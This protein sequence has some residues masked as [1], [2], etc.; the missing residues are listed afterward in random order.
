MSQNVSALRPAVFLDR[1]GTIIVHVDHLNKPEQVRLLPGAAQAIHA[2][3]KAGFLV[4]IFTNQ[5]AI[6]KGKLTEGV[7]E[8]IHTTLKARLKKYNA[9]IDAIYYCPHHTEGIV[10]QY[11]KSCDCRK[12]DIGMITKAFKHHA[13]DSRQSFIIGDTTGDILAGNRA[14]L[15]TI[16][17]ETGYGGTDALHPGKPDYTAKNLKK[18]YEVMKKHLRSHHGQSGGHQKSKTHGKDTKPARKL[19]RKSR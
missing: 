6:A 17:V 8:E 13:I 1:D 19:V 10:E 15:T 18:A 9:H 14:K 2:M 4:I 16:L 12:P 5:A 11:K 3:N 7:L